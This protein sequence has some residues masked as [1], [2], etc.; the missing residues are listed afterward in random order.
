VVS[1]GDENNERCADTGR[2]CERTIVGCGCG[3]RGIAGGSRG[4]AD[5]DARGGRRTHSRTLKS[6]NE[7]FLHF[8]LFR[9]RER[10][11]PGFSNTMTLLRYTISSSNEQIKE[12]NMMMMKK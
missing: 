8:V 9:S 2:A 7:F 6:T 3:F 4:E 10:R 11:I 5:A 1:S 12:R